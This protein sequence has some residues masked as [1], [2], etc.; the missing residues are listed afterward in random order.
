MLLSLSGFLIVNGWNEEESILNAANV[1][2]QA[3]ESTTHLDDMA[4]WQEERKVQ[5][6]VAAS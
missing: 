6:W 4:A 2:V 5:V 3:H 1:S